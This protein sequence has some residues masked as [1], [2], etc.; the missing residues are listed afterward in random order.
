M[1]KKWTLFAG[2]PQEEET[3]LLKM[4]SRHTFNQHSSIFRQEEPLTY[5]HFI[6]SGKVKVQRV[7][8][9]GKEQ[10]VSFQ[11]DGDMFPHIGIF[12]KGNY[13][14]DAVAVTDTDIILISVDNLKQL[15][16]V[17]PEI[18]YN[19][20]GVMEEK[21]MDL[22]KWLSEMIMN[23]AN[24]RVLLL[25]TRLSNSHGEADSQDRMVFNS[26]FTNTELANMIGTSRETVNRCIAQLK[27]HGV[28]D[29]TSGGFFRLDPLL[30][31]EELFKQ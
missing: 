25:L 20:H 16:K 5:L 10:V 3:S 1:I 4:A 31:E 27:A 8:V 12:R 2:L 6:V 15:M 24:E 26:R 7:D 22:Q 19:L 23:N 30:L 18:S 13:P 17:Y 21:V 28:L 9:S 11:Q 14:A 29:I